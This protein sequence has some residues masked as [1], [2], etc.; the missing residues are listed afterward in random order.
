MMNSTPPPILVINI[1]TATRRWAHVQQQVQKN[2]PDAPY[3]RIDAVDCRSLPQNT[4]QLPVSL[5]T[6]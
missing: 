6:Q 4:S 5:F 3:H 1:S 2:I